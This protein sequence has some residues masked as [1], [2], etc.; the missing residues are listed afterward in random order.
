MENRT[1]TLEKRMD[2][3]FAQI[4]QQFDHLGKKVNGIHIELNKT[5]ETVG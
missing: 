3:G 1:N 2:E 5:Q 4:D